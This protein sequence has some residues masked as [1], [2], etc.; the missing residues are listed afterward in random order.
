MQKR[1]VQYSLIATALIYAGGLMA[2]QMMFVLNQNQGALIGCAVPVPPKNDLLADVTFSELKKALL[3][4]YGASA[5]SAADDKKLED[6]LNAMALVESDG[7]P[8]KIEHHPYLYVGGAGK[9]R[10]WK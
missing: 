10:K 8:I 1:L 3:E 2:I 7:N 6:A 9:P 4:D 5:P